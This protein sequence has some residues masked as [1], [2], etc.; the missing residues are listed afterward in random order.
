M[1]LRIT[2][3]GTVLGLWDDAIDWQAL[4]SVSVRRA[5]HVEFCDRRQLWRVRPGQSRNALRRLL[6]WMLQRPCGEILHWAATRSA[7][8]AWEQEHFGPGGPG[9]RP[10]S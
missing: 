7:A 2:P 3:A 8:L 5:S 1:K 10:G 9:W 4:G 6:Q